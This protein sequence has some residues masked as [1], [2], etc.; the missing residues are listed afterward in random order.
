MGMRDP[1]V[2][3]YIEQAAP[4]AQPILRHL[5][6]VVHAGCPDVEETVKWRFPTFMHKGILA[7]V[8]AFKEHCTF[9]FWK[10]RL[11]TAH[12]LVRSDEKAMGQF[13]CLRS[14]KDLPDEKVL[15][16][17]VK[18][19]AALNDQ[20]VKLPPRPT[21]KAKPLV[22]PAYF[23]AALKKNKKALATF[24]AFS[25]SHKKEY[26]VWVTEAKT[27]E[28]RRRRLDTAVLWMSQGKTRNWKYENC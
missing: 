18:A 23:T 25:P 5:R 12:G 2:D 20:G 4:F 11:L 21:R 8:G 28:T 27:E 10:G 3:A 1:R 22:T 7:G 13:G 9:G 16:R 19:A 6:K 15:L 24:A 14:L 17:L 26:V